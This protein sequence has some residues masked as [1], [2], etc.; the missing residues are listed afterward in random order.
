V[1]TAAAQRSEVVDV[2]SVAG[3]VDLRV[4]RT[5]GVTALQAAVLLPDGYDEQPD[6]RWPVLYLLHGVGDDATRWLDPKKGDAQRRATGFPGIIVMPEGGR[7]YYT[8]AWLGGS[9]TRMNWERYLLDEVLPAMEQRYRIAPGRAH[10]AIGGLSMG[11]YGATLLGAQLPSYFGTILNFSGL[12]NIEDP[13][14]ETL[15]PFFSHF[16]YTRQWGRPR[17]PYA[18]AHNPSRLLNNLRATRLYVATGNGSAG[19]D[20]PFDLSPQ[21]FGGLTELLELHDSERFVGLA[22][23]AG[24]DVTFRSHTVGVHYWPYWRRALQAAISW[25]VFGEPAGG[26]TAQRTSFTYRTMAPHGNAWGIGFRFAAPPSAVME[27]TRDGQHLAASGAGTVTVTPGAADA[28]A[29]GAGAQSACQ[30]TAALPF[31]RELPAGC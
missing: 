10:H 20:V 7:G 2:P 12:F 9:R 23:G 3:N 27:M 18:Q 19:S 15:I 16:S 22:R 29:T 13:Q 5:N 6:R 31:S 30:F 25:G 14:A 24:L 28:D 1:P 11:A 4:A 8:D 26:S 17:G 21:V